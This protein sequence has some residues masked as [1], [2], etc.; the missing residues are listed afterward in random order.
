MLRE[1]LPDLADR[2]LV[3]AV[4]EKAANV[5]RLLRNIARDFAPAVFANSLGA[6]D[7]VLTDMIF[8]EDLDIG[9]FSLDTGRLPEET[10]DLIAATEARYG[11]RSRL[12]IRAT[13]CLRRRS[14]GRASTA[15]TTRS[16]RARP[17][18][19]RAR[20][21]RCSAHWP[22]RRHGSPACAQPSRQRATACRPRLTTRP[23]TWSS[24][25]R[26]PTG[27]SARSG[28]IC[29]PTRCPT[30]SCTTR[31]TRASAAP[32]ARVPCSPARM[33]A[34]VAGGGK[35]RNRRNA[36]CMWWTARCSALR[37]PARPKGTFFPGP[38]K[39]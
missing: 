35:P 30:T 8:R 14:P 28:S 11:R 19:T 24:S 15:S 1:N 25:A 6:E 4:A 21:S 23:T 37:Q 39:R 3:D 26:W 20:S 13:I 29:A 27:A 12:P 32:P 31:T 9:I 33:S 5:R 18:A 2:E 38:A 22:A 7:M 36:D 10:H 16:R 34:P 17:A